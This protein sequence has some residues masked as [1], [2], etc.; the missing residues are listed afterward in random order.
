MGDDLNDLIEE[1]GISLAEVD[2]ALR[3]DSAN[4]DLLQVRDI[5]AHR[6]VK[7]EQLSPRCAHPHELCCDVQVRED[8]Q[9][10]RT[11]LL[12]TVETQRPCEGSGQVASPG[13]PEPT[14][15]CSASVLHD[16][17]AARSN[18]GAPPG[19][20][21]PMLQSIAL[22]KSAPGGAILPG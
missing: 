10:A 8:L 11:E 1:N 21:G 4:E 22:C 19:P 12:A 15:K 7:S 20:I 14:H 16:K 3:S 17:H 6:H 2:D 5:S 18:M 9:A 13:Q